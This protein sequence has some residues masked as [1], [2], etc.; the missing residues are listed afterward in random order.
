MPI[1]VGAEEEL[2]TVCGETGALAPHAHGAVEPECQKAGTLTTE[3]HRCVIELQTRICQRPREVAV[4]L[5]RLRQVALARCRPQGQRIVASGVHPFSAW[6][7]QPLFECPKDHPHYASLL[8]EYA[9]VARGALSFG[10][11]VHLGLNG[12]S[13]MPVMNRLRH[14]LPEILAL[15]VSAPFFAGRDTGLQSWRH[16]I[17]GRYPRMGIPEVW[18]SEG[19][20]WEH[21][22]RLRALGCIAPGQG[23][24]EDLRLHHVYPTIEVRIADAVP[25]LRRVELIVGLLQ[26]EALTIEAELD[27]GQAPAILPRMLLE[28]NKWRARRHGLQ[29]KLVDWEDDRVLE[30]PQRL[31]EWSR[32]LE[33]AAQELGYA[34]D[35]QEGLERALREGAVA[36]QHRELRKQHPEW[37]AFVLA[38]AD[39]TDLSAREVRA[40][41]G[42]QYGLA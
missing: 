29:A 16:S 2:Q 31:E 8:A 3:I 1:N 26:C 18:Q 4:S 22:D 28:E 14:V 11:H 7:D 40:Q 23:L 32:R 35:L 10:L 39:Q 30:M 6:E 25:C 19:A 20:Y 33:P 38:I 12:R 34:S 21:V 13:R 15:S 42:V 17:L 36:Q 9:D 37:P 5:A 41:W 24:W 27:S